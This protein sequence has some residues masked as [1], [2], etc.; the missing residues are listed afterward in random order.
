LDTLNI[1]SENAEMYLVSLALLVEGGHPSPVP[2]PL[3]ANALEIKAVSANQMVRK[4]E[5]EGLV[6][7]QPYKGVTLT[8]DGEQIVNLILRNRRLWQV[9]F[10]EKLGFSAARADELACRMEHITEPEVAARLESYLEHP[11]TSPTGKAIPPADEKMPLPKG[12]SLSALLPGKSGEVVSIQVDQATSAYLRSENLTFGTLV[13]MLAASSSGVLL[14]GYD[15]KKISLS[16]EMAEK[17]I[18][19]QMEAPKQHAA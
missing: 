15:G 17:I 4:L 1:H 18:V 7:Y 12:K 9:F 3:L 8:E 13:T 2:L 11:T 19:T 5:E 6:H 14:L 16:A 10:V